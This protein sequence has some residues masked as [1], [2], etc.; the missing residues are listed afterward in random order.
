MSGLSGD[1]TLVGGDRAD[2]LDGGA[3]NDS[4]NGGNGDDTLIGGTGNDTLMGGTG[5]DTYVFNKG[6]GVDTIYDADWTVGNA[7][8][9]KLGA[10]ITAAGTVVTR[11][12]DDAVLS[13]G[14][15]DQVTIQNYFSND[16][17]RV[18]KINFADGTVW[19][20][21]QPGVAGPNA[22]TG[23]SGN[24]VY[25][26]DNV[27][28]TIS[29]S[30]NGGTDWVFSSV[31]FTLPVNVE[32]IVL[33][34]N[35]TISATGNALNNTLIG[36]AAA[37]TLTGGAGADRF[38]FNKAPSASNI[39]TITDFS[40]SQGDKIVLDRTVFAKLASLTSLASNFRLSTQTAVGADDYIVYNAT[41]GQLS[42]DASGVG[43][44]T[45][46]VFATLINKPQDITAQQFVVI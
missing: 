7:D 22:M 33:V 16:G 35:A 21:L 9:L 26:V 4:L 32:N 24:S 2:S 39:D 28:D 37:N 46:Q 8:T 38:V 18:E 5:N 12:N 41:N 11:V 29:E 34:G 3:G 43:A 40:A 10:G 44:G 15:G 20:E 31:N 45:A 25:I 42:Y 6:D 23:G 36:N 19:D 14:G 30:I 1:D 17:F 27:A 13:F